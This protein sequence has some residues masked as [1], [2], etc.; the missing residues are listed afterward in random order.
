MAQSISNGIRGWLLVFVIWVALNI[1]AY[2]A[3]SLFQYFSTWE[4]MQ[5]FRL[6]SAIDC[7][8]V[9]LWNLLYAWFLKQFVQIRAGSLRKIKIMLVLTPIF[10]TVEPLLPV[11]V[12]F[13]QLEG[14]SFTQIVK[15]MYTAPTTL[16]HLGGMYLATAIWLA[17]L[18]LSKRV[19]NTFAGAEAQR[20]LS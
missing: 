18:C 20:G 10:T 19:K 4:E 11:S 14:I 17:Y 8:A 13:S 12:V 2:I 16:A 1:L 6:A 3:W 7:M 5:S 9:L 15:G